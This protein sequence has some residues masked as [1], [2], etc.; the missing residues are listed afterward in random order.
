MRA[1]VLT[2]DE[3][4]SALVP[5]LGRHLGLRLFVRSAPVL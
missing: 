5:N 2:P 4:K 3:L 1:S